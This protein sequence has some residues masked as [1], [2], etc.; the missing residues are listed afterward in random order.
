MLLSLSLLFACS[1]EIDDKPAAQVTPTPAKEAPAK[2]AAPAGDSLPLKAEG[3]TVGFVGA[4]VTGSHDGGFKSFKGGLTVSDGQPTATTVTIDMASA[5]ADHPKLSKHLISDDFFDVAQFATASFT[6]SS[7]AASD[8]GFTVTGALDFHGQSNE[9]TFPATIAVT[10]GGAT[11]KAEFTIDRQQW[12]VAYPGKPDDLI[13]DDVLIKLD[14]VF[15][16]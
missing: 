6:S 4:K 2:P 12:G 15:G 5:F 3:S 1:T 14:L 7:I 9:I 16:S 11:A 8:T 10:D 13:K